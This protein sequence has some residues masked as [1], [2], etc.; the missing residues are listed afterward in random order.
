MVPWNTSPWPGLSWTWAETTFRSWRWGAD[1]ELIEVRGFADGALVVHGSLIQTLSRAMIT[2][3]WF[4]TST[5][6]PRP[7]GPEWL[8]VGI[9]HAQKMF[10]LERFHAA[11]SGG[12]AAGRLILVVSISHPPQNGAHSDLLRVAH[13]HRIGEGRNNALPPLPVVGTRSESHQVLLQRTTRLGIPVRC[14][15]NS[16]LAALRSD[17]DIGHFDPTA[18]GGL[19]NAALSESR[20]VPPSFLG[21]ERSLK[22]LSSLC[23]AQS[24]NRGRTGVV[25]DSLMEPSESASQSPLFAIAKK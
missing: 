22:Y 6:P 21:A 12:L 20:L 14:I 23:N 19:K 13:A 17:I 18:G 5:W 1:V 25:P 7:A 8:I 3:P 4:A 15:E 24:S 16:S 11:Q 10:P 9:K 2:P